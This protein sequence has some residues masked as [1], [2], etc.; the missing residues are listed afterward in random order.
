VNRSPSPRSPGTTSTA[1]PGSTL[2]DL[3]ALPPTLD[4]ETAARLLGIGRTTAYQ[5]AA[6]NALPIPVLRIGRTLRIPTTPLLTLLGITPPDTST[7]TEPGPHGAAPECHAAPPGPDP[8]DR[9]P[10]VARNAQTRRAI[11]NL[12]HHR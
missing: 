4:V 3:T 2:D 6:R 12:H 7:T 9:D 8:A 11:K 1:A 5:L 10:P